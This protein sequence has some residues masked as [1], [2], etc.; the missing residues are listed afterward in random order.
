MTKSAR[1]KR[2]T[3]FCQKAKKTRY[4]DDLEAKIAISRLSNTSQRDT[5]PHR[6]YRCPFCKG[7]HLTSQNKRIDTEISS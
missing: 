6:T 7:W 1:R 4:R 5:I 2:H 3:T